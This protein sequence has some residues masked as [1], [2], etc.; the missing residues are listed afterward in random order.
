MRL[1]TTSSRSENAVEVRLRWVVQQK[2][3]ESQILVFVRTDGTVAVQKETLRWDSDSRVSV[4]GGS[5]NKV[6]AQVPSQLEVTSVE[7]AGLEGWTLEDDPANA[8]QTRVTL[9]YRQPFT[10]DRVIKIRGV[11]GSDRCVVHRSGSITR[12]SGFTANS[13]S[14]IRRSHRAHRTLD[15][16]SRRR[17]APR[18]RNR[19]RDPS[20]VGG[21]PGSFSGSLR[22][23]FLAAA[24]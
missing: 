3:S 7:S 2:E 12:Q 24:V 20:H 6:V 19:R 1:Q 10:N 15:C 5:I 18:L 9:T 23:R 8:G 11:C 13:D 14:A 21:G 17:T 22:V 16:D 4:F